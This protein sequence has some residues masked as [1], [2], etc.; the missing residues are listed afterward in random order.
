MTAQLREFFHN[1]LFKS[2]I[3]W[4]YW[5]YR[6]YLRMRQ[7]YKGTRLSIIWEPLS[8]LLFAFVLSFVWPAV[9]GLDK[10]FLDYFLHILIG[11]SMWRLM[12]AG[13][14]S[15]IKIIMNS[16]SLSVPMSALILEEITMI[17]IKFALHIPAILLLA[18][19]AGKFS[20]LAT[21]ALFLAFALILITSFG[22]GYLGG[23]ICLIW[24]DIREMIQM[25]MRFGIW[26]TPIVWMPGERFQDLKIILYINPFYWYLELGRETFYQPGISLQILFVT[27]MITVVVFTLGYLTVSLQQNRIKILLQQ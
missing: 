12:S 1:D 24:P 14:L 26:V 7:Q 10:P 17:A 13:V 6:A 5:V 25:V 19:I 11:F 20:L 9:L 8:T 2:L 3:I 16:S 21:F 15:V 23:T 27:V 22:V 18:A 4:R